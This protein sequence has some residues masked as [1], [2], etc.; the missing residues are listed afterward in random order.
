VR[1]SPPAASSG[2]ASRGPTTCAGTTGP[3]SPQGCYLLRT[4]LKETDPA[5][6]WKRDLQLT[7]AEVFF[8]ELKS[9]MQFEGYVLMKFEAVERHLD[10]FP[11]GLLKCAA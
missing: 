6:L 9:R 4:N 11:M 10:L 1:I 8:R 2:C 5:L 3:H 7:E